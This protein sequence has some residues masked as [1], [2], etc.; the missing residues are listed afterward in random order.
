MVRM[1]Q[2]QIRIQTSVSEKIAQALIVT[3]MLL[4]C[5]CVI[6]PFLNILAVSLSGKQEVMS[7][8]VTFYPRALTTEAYSKVISDDYFFNSYRNTVFVVV[9]SVISAIVCTTMTA[10]IMSRRDLPGKKF[11]TVMITIPMWFNGGLIPGF[12][13]IRKLGLYDSL[14]SL[15]VPG[16]ISVYN[17]IVIRN[18]FQ[19]LPTALEESAMIDGANDF[20]IL[21][22]IYIPLSIPCIA[23][24][25]LWI[26][27]GRWNEYTAALLYLSSRSKYTLQ[28]L[29]R[30]IVFSNALSADMAISDTMEIISESIKYA[31]IILTI[32][33]IL[34]VY[35][36]LQKY[37]VKGVTVGAVKG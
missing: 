35:P 6:V 37:F 23:T 20:T 17:A 25:A 26:I 12:L 2:K 1:K 22:K 24:V 14:W 21:F 9:L 3:F 18:F 7:G 4:F 10:Y 32:L 34:C 31:N 36:F 11:I 28:L 33:P 15:I 16:L 29:L 5:A 30:E 8:R 27:V 13:L 19:G